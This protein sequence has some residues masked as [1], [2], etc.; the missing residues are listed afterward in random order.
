MV[1]LY[2]TEHDVTHTMETIFTRRPWLAPLILLGL[3]LLLLEPA[4]LPNDPRHALDG[5]D[6]TGNFYPLYTFTAEQIADGNLPLWNPYQFAGFPVAGNPQAAVFYPGTWLLWGLNALLNVSVPRAMGLL[7]L[8]HVFFAAWGSYVLA[9]SFGITAVGALAAAVIY[10]MSGWA[11]S[12]IY[13]GHFTILTVYAWIP[14]VMAGYRWALQQRTGASLLAPTAFLGLAALA[15]HPQMVLYAALGLAV[16]WGYHTVTAERVAQAAWAGLWRLAVIGIGGILLG[17]ALL[18]PTA[19]LVAQ[20]ARTDTTLAFL[21]T[22]RLPTSQLTTLALPF[23]YGNPKEVH[24]R[25]W[26][27]DFFEETTAYA[28]LLALVALPVMLRAG[29]RRV[30]FW[31]A[32][33]VFGLVLAIGADGVLFALLVRWL[34]GFSLFRSPGRFLYFVTLGLAGV[35]GLLF[36][37]L[38]SATPE[39]RRVTLAPALR[40]LPYVGVGLFAGSVFFSGWFASASHVEPMP[41]RATQIAGVLGYSAVMTFATWGVLQLLAR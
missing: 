23:L 30:F 17:L 7:V 36:T 38:Q 16:L 14:F 31:L 22:F 2:L 20:T 41:I 5:N 12:R 8:L 6:F 37:H 29:D 13:A 18:L 33:V 26:G 15:G 27:A 11:G 32:L 4:I 9:R 35:T 39:R 40:V 19:E 28:G 3:A 10:S 1:W 21:N 34:P 24:I 25:Y